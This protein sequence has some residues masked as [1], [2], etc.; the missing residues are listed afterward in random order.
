MLL[1]EGDAEGAA[2]KLRHVPLTYAR[3][4]DLV[5]INLLELHSLTPQ[6]AACK[7][8]ADA[9][10]QTGIAAHVSY[11]GQI[12]ADVEETDISQQAVAAAAATLATMTVTGTN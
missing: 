3:K 10:A 6:M 12:R 1:A 4:F 9:L 7:V 5:G 2:H 8:L 11:A